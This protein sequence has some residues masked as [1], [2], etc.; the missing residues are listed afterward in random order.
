MGVKG[1]GSAAIC[2][3]EASHIMNILGNMSGIEVTRRILDQDPR[4][5]II[6]L[7]MRNDEE[8][9]GAMREAGAVAYLDK[10]G[11]SKTLIETIRS[12]MRETHRRRTYKA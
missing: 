9:A 2:P 10:S 7:S 4:V 6:G 8:T 12:C 1:L 5:R 11:S 3:Y